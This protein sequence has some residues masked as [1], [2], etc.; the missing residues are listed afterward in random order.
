MSELIKLEGILK[1]FPGV[2]AL[3]DIN[4]DI[5]HGESVAIVGENGAGKSTLIK[6]LSGAY[7]PDSGSITVDGQTFKKLTPAQSIAVGVAV[8]Y[9]E[10]NYLNYLTIAENIFLGSL[11]KKLGLVD[12]AKLKENSAGIQKLIGLDHLDPFTPVSELSVAEKQLIEIARAY[13]RNA[14]LIIMDEPTSALNEDETEKLFDVIHSLVENG[15]SVIYVSH[16]LEE[17]N[18]VASRV[19]VMRDGEKVFEGPLPDTQR[20]EIIKHMVG[21]SIEN[22][23]PVEKKQTGDEVLT[24]K[25]FCSNKL[26]NVTLNVRKNEIVGIY[27]LMGSGMTDF[28]L[29][30][31]SG[32]MTSGSVTVDKKEVV[33]KNPDDSIKAGL[34][35]VPGER[36]TEG[37]ITLQ[38]V[39]ANIS[40]V[41]LDKW[42]N[43][44]LISRHKEEEVANKWVEDLSIKTPSIHTDVGS[45]SGGNQQKVVFAKWAIANPKVFLMIDPTKGV[46]VGAKVDIYKEMEALCSQGCGILVACSELPE[47]LGI[48]NRVYVM[49][50]GKIVAEYEG[51]RLT[52]DNVVKSAIGE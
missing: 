10:L 17:I 25:D 24:V 28:P 50:E 52:K 39:C 41:T 14:K 8:I 19:I 18:S 4:L 37:I 7:Q 29:E 13:S 6:V 36:K 51:D 40:V 3:K 11:P 12:Y 34:A 21:H 32:K 23:Y 27:G 31:F 2:I 16:K 49:H 26:Q 47:L 1:R 45:L 22:L 20:P 5:G 44:P 33:L 35:L 42:K 38:S 9:Q 30:L 43:G 48:A 46:D 15:K